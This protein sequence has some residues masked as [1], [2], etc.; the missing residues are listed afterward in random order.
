MCT[1]SARPSTR[2][3][4]VQAAAAD[5]TPPDLTPPDP[6]LRVGDPEREH[7]AARLGLA[8]THGY[9]SM[10]EYEN[11]LG[12]A[13]AAQTAGD[14]DRL[15]T[16]LPVDQ[17]SRR[18]PRRQTARRHAALRGLQVHLISYVA[19][20]LLMIGIWLAVGVATDSWYFW[21]IWPILGVG[22]G[23]VGHTISVAQARPGVPSTA[24]VTGVPQPFNIDV[25]PH[26]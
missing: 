10:E 4:P 24:A 11:R 15:T 25:P 1:T 23:V 14:L 7:T 2:R 12:Q 8:F 3:S 13:F 21:P 22:I 20:S 5:L 26:G 16:D 9:L 6:T 18:D 19:M 17:I